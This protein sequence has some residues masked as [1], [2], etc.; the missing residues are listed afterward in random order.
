M[1]MRTRNK[2]SVRQ[3]YSE[4]ESLSNLGTLWIGYRKVTVELLF[5]VQ[6]YESLSAL[7]LSLP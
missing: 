1:A 2:Q 7:N 3:L 4:D 5:V 6:S